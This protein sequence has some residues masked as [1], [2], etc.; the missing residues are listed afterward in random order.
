M[1]KMIKRNW[2][3]LH[4]QNIDLWSS[5]SGK[6]AKQH[7]DDCEQEGKRN[8]EKR[9]KSDAK[10][11]EME[12]KTNERKKEEKKIYKHKPD[13]N[14]NNYSSSI[15]F[16][17]NIIRDYGSSERMSVRGRKSEQVIFEKENL[18]TELI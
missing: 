2:N 13:S 15:Q 9:A 6:G 4:T 1:G 14:L 8:Y 7:S 5:K 10:E 17:L 11:K 16:Q 18:I 12:W 3:C